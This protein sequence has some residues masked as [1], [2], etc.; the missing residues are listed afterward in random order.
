MSWLTRRGGG[1]CT[2]NGSD[3]TT[4]WLVSSHAGLCLKVLIISSSKKANEKRNLQHKRNKLDL[5]CLYTYLIVGML[6]KRNL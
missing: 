2:L 5:R 4:A 1:G 3:I 6:M